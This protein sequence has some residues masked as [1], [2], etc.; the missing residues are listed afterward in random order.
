MNDFLPLIANIIFFLMIGTISLMAILG[1]YVYVRYGQNR[2][3]TIISSLVFITVFMLGIIS[4][5][6]AL[7]DLIGYY[8]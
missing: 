5:Y 8:V 4:S 2:T 1:V 7:Y 6:S 3:F